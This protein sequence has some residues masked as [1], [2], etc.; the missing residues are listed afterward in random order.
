MATIGQT[1]A[2]ARVA[3]G[4]TIADLSSRTRIRE[5]VLRGIEEEDFVPCGGDFYARGHI[6]SLCRTLGVDP[7]P[8]LED[9]DREHAVR[10]HP[11]FVPEARKPASAFRATA[12]GGSGGRSADGGG[13]HTAG[14]GTDEPRRF[15][16]DSDPEADSERWG[17][18]ERGQNLGGRVRI[19]RPRAVAKTLL[20]RR[21]REGGGNGN[22]AEH[23]NPGNAEQASD[24]EGAEGTADAAGGRGTT[25]TEDTGH[26]AGPE[27]GGEPAKPERSGPRPAVT[28]TR[29]RRVEAVSRHW[30]WAVVGIILVLAVIV[31]IRAWNGD[32]TNPLRTA[33]ETVRAGEQAADSSVEG[34]ITADQNAE[35]STEQEQ[36]EDERNA[37]GD[38]GA[39]EQAQG[40]TRS[41]TTV[42]LTAS[43]RSWVKVT[44]SAGAELFTGFLAEGEGRNYVTDDDVTVWLGDA[45][46]ITVSVDGQDIGPAGF[47]GEVREITVGAEGF[48]E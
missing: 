48:G 25:G 20:W 44:D 22:A 5:S 40:E 13:A 14:T 2:A 3:A 17:H 27:G 6:R 31:G 39:V 33:L 4:H 10:G 8:L 43:G 46:A 35:E 16:E 1:L 30:P 11:A 29:R 12:R 47:S 34:E 45:G 38:R 37:R 21:D 18:F 41:E 23:R 36:T 26:T 9:Y 15:G 24:G 19:S 32:G 7:Q 28:R 42:G